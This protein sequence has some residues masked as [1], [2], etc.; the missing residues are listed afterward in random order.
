MLFPAGLIRRAALLALCLSS[1]SAMS[2]SLQAGD[3]LPVRPEAIDFGELTFDPPSATEFKSTL[4]NGVVLYLLQDRALPLINIS[5]SFSGGDY[6]DPIG[7]EGLASLTGAMVRRGGTTTIS[8][9]ELDERFD[10]LA[11]EAGAGIGGESASASL[12]SLVQNF[13]ESFMLFMDM[14][15]NPGFDAERFETLRTQVIEGMKERNDNG[16]SILGRE[17]QALMYGRDHFEARQST[18]ASIESITIEDMRAFHKTIFH[19]GNLVIGVTGDFE[20][21]SIKKSLEAALDGW[22]AGERPAPPPRSDSRTL[23]RGLLCREGHPPGEGIHRHA[24]CE[25]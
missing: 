3:E 7:K 10:F 4:S 20:V 19:P 13:D 23:P 5:F 21:A 8:P 12:D 14:L 2:H 18:I 16:N 22:P 24:W 11:A 9:E 17:W 1:L 15:R 6:L 25:T